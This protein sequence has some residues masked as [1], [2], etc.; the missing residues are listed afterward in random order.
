MSSRL[1][2]WV[3]AASSS[4]SSPSGFLTRRTPSAATARGR[5]RRSVCVPRTIPRGDRVL[6]QGPGSPRQRKTTTSKETGAQ[7]NNWLTDGLRHPAYPIAVRTSGACATRAQREVPRALG[8]LATRPSDRLCALIAA[9]ACSAQARRIRGGT[10][11]DGDRAGGTRRQAVV[12]P[13][14]ERRQLGIFGVRA[15]QAGRG[16]RCSAALGHSDGSVPR[17][18]IDDGRPRPRARAPSRRTCRIRCAVGVSAAKCL[19]GVATRR[20]RRGRGRTPLRQATAASARASS[21]NASK[22]R[23]AASISLPR[24]RGVRAGSVRSRQRASAR[25]ARSASSSYQPGGRSCGPTCRRCAMTVRRAAQFLPRRCT[26]PPDLARPR[27]ARRTQSR[28]ERRHILVDVAG[29]ERRGAATPRPASNSSSRAARVR[30]R[31]EL[32]P[33]PR[34]DVARQSTLGRAAA[35]RVS[36]ATS[37]PA[38]TSG[39]AAWVH[40]TGRS[41]RRGG[42]GRRFPERRRRRRARRQP[43]SKA[44]RGRHRAT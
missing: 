39:I 44:P 18:E 7:G 40:G 43:A 29:G 4:S 21:R 14:A 23:R 37:A 34:D 38:L 15:I 19:E 20:R 25:A 41:A 31:V 10:R 26:R 17:A 12:G 1:E 32:A 3:A 9:T 42:V 33:D 11:A 8:D 16:T 27:G 30:G 28:A 22:R 24:A 35:Q 5:P 6:G 36:T 2:P 13:A